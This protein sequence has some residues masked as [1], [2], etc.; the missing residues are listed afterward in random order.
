VETSRRL[1]AAATQGQKDAALA[2][3]K[4]RQ[5]AIED[6]ATAQLADAY[7]RG[8]VLSFY[9]AEQLKGLEV[10]GARRLRLR[11]VELHLA[12]GRRL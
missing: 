7:E 3:S 5:A 8:A 2:D 9:F 11:R 4:T 12:D 1:Q 6:S 10:E